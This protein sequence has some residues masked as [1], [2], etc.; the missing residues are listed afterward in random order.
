MFELEPG[1]IFW[2]FISFII[3]LA[4]LSKFAYPP[5]LKILKKRED[6]I[7][8]QLED[9]KKQKQEAENFSK[10]AKEALNK[11]RQEAKAFLEESRKDAEIIKNEILEKARLETQVIIKQG[12]EQ[13]NREKTEAIK[14]LQENVA[15]LVY[16][17]SKKIVEKTIDEKT[18]LNLIRG[19]I[20]EIENTKQ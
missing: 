3:L 10:E 8:D 11:S 18:H 7:K 17:A 20:K 12:K 14:K 2:T 1:L 16:L 13:I 19:A 4:A 9:A 6:E 15:D 5:L